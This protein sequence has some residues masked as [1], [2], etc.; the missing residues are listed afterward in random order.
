MVQGSR[1]TKTKGTSHAAA[2]NFRLFLHQRETQ[3]L[4]KFGI[5]NL[6]FVVPEPASPPRTCDSPILK[7]KKVQRE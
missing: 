7:K 4:E 5:S 6:V 2:L 3:G 1:E